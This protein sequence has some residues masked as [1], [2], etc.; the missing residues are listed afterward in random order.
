MVRLVLSVSVICGD[1]F[2]LE[3]ELLRS[4]RG[5]N[6]AIFHMTGSKEFLCVARIFSE[7]IWI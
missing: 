2:G 1:E 7:N 3:S 6:A 4:G 5:H